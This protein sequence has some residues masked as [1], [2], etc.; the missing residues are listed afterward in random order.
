M[1]VLELRSDGDLAEKP[2]RPHRSGHFGPQ[3]FYS[4]GPAVLEVLGEID[5]RHA[6]AT[7]LFFDRGAGGQDVFE[8]FQEVRQASKS[9]SRTYQP[10]E[11]MRVNSQPTRSRWTPVLNW[12][13]SWWTR[14]ES[15]PNHCAATSRS[16]ADLA[17]G[18]FSMIF[19][20]ASSTYIR[21][22]SGRGS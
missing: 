12:V 16:D 21:T 22:F 19:L 9:P 6:P 11:S 2:I 1:G 18:K 5:R 3:D 17:D 13:A 20:T 7:Q 14:S 4:N 15:S 8:A 10:Y